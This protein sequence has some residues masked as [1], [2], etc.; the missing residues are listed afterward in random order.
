MGQAPGTCP[1]SGSGPCS[2]TSTGCCRTPRPDPRGGYPV[3]VFADTAS[4]RNYKGDNEQH[5]WVGI[6][7]QPRAAGR[8]ERHRPARQPHGRDRPTPAAS[9]RP[10]GREPGPRGLSLSVV[11]RT[12]S[13]RALWTS[14]HRPAGSRCPAPPRSRV[15]RRRFSGVLPAAHPPGMAHAIVFDA[16]GRVVEPSA[17]LRK[18]ALIVDRSRHATVGQFH[19]RCRGVDARTR[20]GGDRHGPGPVALVEVSLRTSCGDPPET[21]TLARSRAERERQGGWR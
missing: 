12:I 14:D 13:S 9:P 11:P 20:G 5:A 21:L 7:F 2:T 18:R 8:A 17:V 3:L 15:R 16:S 10:P 19:Q 1:K 6:R 4:A